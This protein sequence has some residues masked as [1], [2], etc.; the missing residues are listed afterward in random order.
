MP[1]RCCRLTV[2]ELIGTGFP[3]FGGVTPDGLLRFGHCKVKQSQV[4]SYPLTSSSRVLK[5][6]VST[7]GTS[8][9]HSPHDREVVDGVWALFSG[10]SELDRKTSDRMSPGKFCS[11]R[12]CNEDEG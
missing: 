3:G 6:K 5:L 12:S 10:S 8:S 7:P 4:P 11:E 9:P 1:A 2:C